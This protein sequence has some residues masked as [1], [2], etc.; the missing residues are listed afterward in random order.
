MIMIQDNSICHE[1]DSQQ[2]LSI[3][4]V[5]SEGDVQWKADI[6]YELIGFVHRISMKIDHSIQKDSS[7]YEQFL[8]LFQLMPANNM[9]DIH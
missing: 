7:N 8:A 9:H 1:E 5:Y 4:C 6:L 2:L 3:E